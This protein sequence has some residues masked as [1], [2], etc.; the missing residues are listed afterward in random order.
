[1]QNFFIIEHKEEIGHYRQT[2]ITANSEVPILIGF[3][4]TII[5]KIIYPFSKKIIFLRNCL[6]DSG[7]HM[8]CKNKFL[9]GIIILVQIFALCNFGYSQKK[10]FVSF[11]NKKNVSFNPYNYFDQKTIDKRLSNNIALYDSSDFPVNNSY[12][13]QLLEITD[14]I[15][16]ISRWLNGVSVFANENQ[17]LLI[18]SLP[19]VKSIESLNSLAV[20]ST[21]EFDTSLNKQDLNL[22]K[23][24]IERMEGNLFISNGIN[25]QGVRIA[26]FDVG[27]KTVNESPFFEHIFSKNKIIKT[28]DFIK[29]SEFVYDYGMHGATVMSCIGGKINNTNIGLATNAE[30]LLART[31]YLVREPFSEEENWLAAAE[32]ADKNGADIINSSLGYVHH[33]YFPS[34]MDGKTSLV[35]R[36]ANMAARKGILVVN[37]MGN[38]GTDDWKYLATPADAD[39]VLSI[40]GISPETNYHT[41][42]SSYGPTADGRLKPNVTSFAHVIAAGKG[43]LHETQGTSFSSPLVAGFAACALQMNPNYSNIEL[44]HEIEKSG[45]L[46]PYYDYAHGYG[47]PQASY[48]INDDKKVVEQTFKFETEGD[49]IKVIVKESEIYG[50]FNLLFYHIENENKQLDKYTVIRVYQSDVIQFS[51]S[52][53]INNEILR[54][55]FKG[56]TSEINF[57]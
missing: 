31:E 34:D 48:F 28:Y 41:S 11:S 30:F 32:W 27:F 21:N 1:M 57:N 10:Y 22:I 35:S 56:Y 39:S 46:Y 54:V 12:L 52:D 17:L 13:K 7:Y 5:L 8:G 26:I 23:G 36:A 45:D 43:N 44:F 33:R 37:S 9:V 24:Q 38:S 40:G 55:H 3:E 2:F 4:N 25:G 53:Y 18:E 14:N 19:F 49:I 50:K 16:T 15:K 20:I 47:V 42:F 6:I 29:N 51:K